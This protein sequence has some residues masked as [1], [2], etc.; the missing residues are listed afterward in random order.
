MFHAANAY[1]NPFNILSPTRSLLRSRTGDEIR[2]QRLSS[3]VYTVDSRSL[4]TTSRIGTITNMVQV[5][6]V[7]SDD[8]IMTKDMLKKFTVKQLKDKIKEFNIPHKPSQL[9]LKNDIVNFLYDRHYSTQSSGDR[10]KEENMNSAEEKGSLKSHRNMESSSKKKIDDTVETSKDNESK[11]TNSDSNPPQLKFSQRD[12]IFEHVMER[13]PPLRDL[14]QFAETRESVE[15]KND[16]HV[17]QSF[18]KFESILSRNP[19]I[20]KSLSGLGDL[21][22]RQEYHPMLKS[23][24]SSDLDIVT[25]GT[26]SCV[27]GVTRGVSCTALRLQWRR[28]NQTVN[29]NSQKGKRQNGANNKQTDVG[30]T[31]GGIWIFDC[32]ESTQVRGMN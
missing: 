8:V 26:A 1:P 25:V 6:K 7:A 32:G 13:Y 15:T 12:I 31:T 16:G 20:A 11:T 24:T 2:R 18:G 14:H 29:H 5:H 9:K 4:T 27:P 19:H 3:Y 30:M 10:T 17:D 23:L 28:N 22:V 21:D